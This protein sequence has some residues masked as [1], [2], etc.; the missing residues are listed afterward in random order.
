MKVKF[1]TRDAGPEG[2]RQPGDVV[3]VSETEGRALVAGGFAEALE[4]PRRGKESQTA[5][6][7]EK[8]ARL[9]EYRGKGREVRGEH[10]LRGAGAAEG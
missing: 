8:G 4:A 10:G 6:G 1:M 2:V 3:D 9:D 5:R 7:G